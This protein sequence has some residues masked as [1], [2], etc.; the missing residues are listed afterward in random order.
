MAVE[1]QNWSVADTET[2]LLHLFHTHEFEKDGRG[3]T[4]NKFWMAQEKL[5][6]RRNGMTAK[7]T[8]MICC[9]GDVGFTKL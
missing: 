8:C 5:T 2:F 1:K 9:Y 4:D 3:K 7:R 6:V